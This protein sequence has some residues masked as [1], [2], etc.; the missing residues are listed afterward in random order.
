M[1][2]SHGAPTLA[3]ASLDLLVQD[4]ALEDLPLEP[5]GACSPGHRLVEERPGLDL[6][7]LAGTLREELAPGG[8]AFLVVPGDP[9]A[10]G[11]AAR[12]NALWPALHAA[13]LYRSRGGRLTRETPGGVREVEGSLELEGAVLVLRRREDA[14]SPDVTIAK[15][16]QNAA[17]WNGDPR[18]PG[19][20]HHRWMRR[21]VGTFVAPRPGARILDFGSGAGWVGIEAALRSPGSSLAAFDPSP[22][23]VRIAGENARA[24]GIERFAGR[25]GFGEDPPFPAPGEEPFDLVLSSGVISFSPD[26]ERWYAGLV[27]SVRPGGTL[28]IGDIHRDSAGFRRRRA[29]RPI[30]P[31][32]EMN[33]RTAAEVRAELERRGFVHRRTCGYQLTRPVPEAMHLSETRLHGLLN[34]PLLLLNR[35]AASTVGGLLPDRFDSWV[36]HLERPA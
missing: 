10:A 22:E 20:G 4:L 31:T 6:A 21:F 29:R 19:Y 27:A 14:M 12:R 24:A 8:T 1:D 5:L 32:R 7:A 17:G 35:L 13:V 30:L 26:F 15:F 23:M 36:M 3:P 11:L 2:P 16:D 28:V 33:A 9:D 34:P 25:T 18:S